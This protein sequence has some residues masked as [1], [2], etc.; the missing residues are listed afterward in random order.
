MTQETTT[1]KK[2]SI[3]SHITALRRVLLISVVAVLV[4]F[5]VLF[6]V[7]CEPLVTFILRPVTL[8]GIPV[9]ATAVSDAL[10]MKFKVCLVGAVVVA[11]PVIIWQI[12]SFIRPALY[13]HEKRVF[14]LLFF[15]ALLLFITGIVFCY[16]VIFPLTVDLFW[17]AAEGVAQSLW[18]VKEY[19]NFV[20]TFV[21]PFGVMFEMPV[22]MYM[23][24]RKGWLTY[25]SAAKSRKYVILGLSVVAAIL[26]PPDVVSQ[27]MLLLPMVALYEIS[28]Q[29]MRIVAKAKADK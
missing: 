3:I 2:Q 18:N 5:M 14:K 26:T 6:Y 8:R 12:W 21:L 19:F 17:E 24:A 15:I 16:L 11:M 1:E 29:L 10:V 27:L 9:M 7:F 4:A 25:E 23:M 20:L 22:V 28:L 13:P